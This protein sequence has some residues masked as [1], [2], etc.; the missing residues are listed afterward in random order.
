MENINQKMVKTGDEN[1]VN[2]IFEDPGMSEVEQV[3]ALDYD[4]MDWMDRNKTKL[5]ETYIEKNQAD[6]YD[7]CYEEAEKVIN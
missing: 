2:R 6:F 5:K 4:R 7:F 3:E 1:P